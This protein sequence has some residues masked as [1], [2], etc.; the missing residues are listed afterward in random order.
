VCRPFDTIPAR[1]GRTDGRTDGIAVASTALA[2]RRAVKIANFYGRK[3][4]EGQCLS[5]CQILWR[6]VKPLLRYGHISILQDGGRRHLRFLK[7]RIIKGRK[8]QEGQYASNYQF[9]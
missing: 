2:V 3:D 7:G 6:S 8:G 1:D 4:Q 9:S 5:R